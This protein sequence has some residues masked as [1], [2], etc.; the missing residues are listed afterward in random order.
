MNKREFVELVESNRDIFRCLVLYDASISSSHSKFVGVGIKWN[1][2]HILT[3]V[4]VMRGTTDDLKAKEE[5]NRYKK[6]INE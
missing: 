4:K 1:N 2:V 5:L 6:Y 3:E